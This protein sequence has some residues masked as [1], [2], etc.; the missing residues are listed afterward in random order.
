M[1]G[2]VALCRSCVLD[3]RYPGIRF[4]EDGVCNYCSS[5]SRKEGDRNARE[6]YKARFVELAEGFRG[7]RSYDCVLAYSGGKDSTFTL[8]LL[9]EKYGLNVLA[10]SF[11]NWFQSEQAQKNIRCVVKTAGVDHI[12]MR[13]NFTLFRQMM[14][15][16]L[17]EELYGR[18]ALERATSVCITCLSV[19]R[20]LCFKTAIEK[21]I[22]FVVFGLSPGQAPMATSVTKVNPAMIRKMQDAIYRPLRARIGDGI[23]VYFLESWHFE[24]EHSFPYSVNP[25]AFSKYDEKEIMEVAE[26][27]GWKKPD[28]TDANSTN[29]LLNGFANQVHMEKYGFH[30]Y[31][32]EIGRLVRQ[33]YMTREEGLRKISSPSDPKIVALVKERLDVK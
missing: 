1:K 6:K 8:H 30:P 23:R 21:S 22:P 25:L 16:S 14:Q 20:F 27:Y 5:G 10:F 33:G 15:I 12:T 26:R 9:K 17:T 31:A 4:G 32:F 29:C 11:D 24:Q 3:E 28:D 19:I 7:R 18:K 2:P 13:P